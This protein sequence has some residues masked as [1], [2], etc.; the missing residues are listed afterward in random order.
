MKMLPVRFYYHRARVLA[1]MLLVCMV[2]Y[3]MARVFFEVPK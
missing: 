2:A 3:V 1:V